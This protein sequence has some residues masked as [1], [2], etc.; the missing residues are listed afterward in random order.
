MNT[1]SLVFKT[2]IRNAI[3]SCILPG[4]VLGTEIVWLYFKQWKKEWSA[5]GLAV[6]SVFFLHFDLP[7]DARSVIIRAFIE[8]ESN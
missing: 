7:A 4:T 2:F 3:D 5:I 8:H 1:F 6:L